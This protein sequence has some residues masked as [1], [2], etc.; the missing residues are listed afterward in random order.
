MECTNKDKDN[1]RE[2]ETCPI[3]LLQIAANATI[4]TKCNH[5][6]CSDC[7]AKWQNL[8]NTCPCCRNLLTEDAMET[9]ENDIY[10]F[11]ISP[12]EHVP[13]GTINFS[14]AERVQLPL[15][16][17]RPERDQLNFFRFEPHQPTRT[18]TRIINVSE[19]RII[20]NIIIK[21]FTI[22]LLITI[23]LL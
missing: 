2:E 16:F 4:V 18:I 9:N 8:K 3:C 20:N 12:E 10:F 23:F 21:N 1:D 13:S 22:F 15:N 19:T 14:R 11:T 5:K 6:F 7:F 17:F